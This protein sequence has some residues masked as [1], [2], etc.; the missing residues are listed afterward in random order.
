VGGWVE[1]VALFLTSLVVWIVHAVVDVFVGGLGV[2][3]EVSVKMRTPECDCR[4]WSSLRSFESL[5][6]AYKVRL[7]GA[8]TRS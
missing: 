5:L 1:P 8:R 7:I 4:G 2:G 3:A 6:S